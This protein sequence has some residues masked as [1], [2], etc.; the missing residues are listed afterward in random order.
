MT[1]RSLVPGM[2]V[3]CSLALEGSDRNVFVTTTDFTVSQEADTPQWLE[4]I[5]YSSDQL[6]ADYERT[7]AGEN[8]GEFEILIADILR[9]SAEGEEVV[10]PVFFEVAPVPEE[11][12]EAP[13]VE[14]PE[15]MR[16]KQLEMENA[17]L[18]ERLSRLEPF[19]DPDWPAANAQPRRRV[20][21]FRPRRVRPA[22]LDRPVR[23]V[24]SLS[25]YA[26]R[27]KPFTKAAMD[28]QVSGL[29]PR[30]QGQSLQQQRRFFSNASKALGAGIVSKE[31]RGIQL[32]VQRAMLYGELN[33]RYA[34]Q[35]LADVVDVFRAYERMAEFGLTD[36]VAPPMS[37]D[38][39]R[40]NPDVMFVWASEVNEQQRKLHR[41]E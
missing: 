14:T 20:F 21:R 16:L 37:V 38:S 39:Y 3:L 24:V 22:D 15:V 2:F 4:A 30:A 28:T 27:F 36:G 23:P 8:A 41:E 11:D 1:L 31:Y 7:I 26:I 10:I 18:K 13:V 5:D 40:R 34:V 33:A 6:D 9:R 17:A 32:E 29:I 35:Y 12:G 25:R 19:V